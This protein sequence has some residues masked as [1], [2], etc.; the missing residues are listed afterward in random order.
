LGNVISPSSVND[1]HDGPTLA[2]RWS[3]ALGPCDGAMSELLAGTGHRHRRRIGGHGGGM[4]IGA[5]SSTPYRRHTG[6]Q[7]FNHPKLA[8]TYRLAN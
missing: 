7:D 5:N 2:I 3:T 8:I 4:T 1:P 6:A